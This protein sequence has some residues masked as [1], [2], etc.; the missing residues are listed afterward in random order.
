MRFMAYWLKSWLRQPT[1]R[2]RVSL[3]IFSIDAFSFKEKCPTI[4]VTFLVGTFL[5]KRAR[6]LQWLFFSRQTT[7]LIVYVPQKLLKLL[8]P[9][10]ANANLVQPFHFLP[11]LRN[12]QNRTRLKI[13]FGTVRL[14]F[15]N[16]LMSPKG[17]PFEFFILQQNVCK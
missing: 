12:L 7:D 10:P 1:T 2:V 6:L 8:R 11:F 16:I 17:P 4:A 13:F 5:V 9:S 3:G 15:E 14:F